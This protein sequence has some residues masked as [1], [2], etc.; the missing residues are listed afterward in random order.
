MLRNMLLIGLVLA[1]GSIAAV[2]VP[3]QGDIDI[4]FSPS[5]TI[6]PMT[7]GA[8]TIPV[9]VSGGTVSERL[10]VW[11]NIDL[12]A[13]RT[14]NGLGLAFE[15]TAGATVT[16][17]GVYNPD[18]GVVTSPQFRWSNPET[19][20]PMTSSGY[21]DASA[22]AGPGVIELGY[23]PAFGDGMTGGDTLAYATT[24]GIGSYLV[25]YID[26]DV[27]AVESAVNFAISP[28]WTTRSGDGTGPFGT[29]AFGINDP[30]SGRDTGAGGF[31]GGRFNDV[32]FT[33]EPATLALLAL[34]LFALRRR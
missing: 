33:P 25:G 5:N 2:A 13:Y 9:D 23:T 7:P 24:G 31:A 19:E 18:M 15:S 30:V 32:T 11:A 1:A 4:F 12:N 10:Y 21:L 27:S 16:G 8:P 34:G 6:G 14:W 26:V 3:A 22:V 20:I 29:V 28:A 17:G